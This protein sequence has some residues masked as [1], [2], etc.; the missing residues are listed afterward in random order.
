M[1]KRVRLNSA[2][3]RITKI[4][5]NHGLFRSSQ[6]AVCLPCKTW[7]RMLRHWPVDSDDCGVV[8]HYLMQSTMGRRS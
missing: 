4:V 5:K 8:A 6:A 7:E 2:Q 1:K 3:I